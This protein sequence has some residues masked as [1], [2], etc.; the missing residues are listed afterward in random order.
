[1]PEEHPSGGKDLL[2]RVSIPN[3][4]IPYS[5]DVEVKS[6][7]LVLGGDTKIGKEIAQAMPWP[8]KVMVDATDT[9]V[10]MV[11]VGVIKL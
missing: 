11:R 9:E 2:D 4:P 1:M 7:E 5:L 8:E 10:A 3:S 6:P